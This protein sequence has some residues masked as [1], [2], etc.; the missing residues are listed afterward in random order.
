MQPA[1]RIATAT[2]GYTDGDAEYFLQ[3]ARA[4]REM[5]RQAEA[6]GARLAHRQLA[7]SY[8][9]KAQ[10]IRRSKIPGANQPSLSPT[11]NETRLSSRERFCRTST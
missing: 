11:P 9:K 8:E 5:E 10:S 7:E 1:L 4:E 6:E 3:R 2:E